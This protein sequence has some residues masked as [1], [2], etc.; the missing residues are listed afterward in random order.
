MTK[1]ENIGPAVQPKLYIPINIAVP[2]EI[3]F[4]ETVS[5]IKAIVKGRIGDIPNPT[6]NANILVAI[7]LSLNERKKKENI[8]RQTATNVVCNLPYLSP[9]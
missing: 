2:G 4:L 8:T 9:M 7:I 6:V 5:P 1:D 3:S